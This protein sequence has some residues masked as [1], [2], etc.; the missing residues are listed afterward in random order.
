MLVFGHRGVAAE[1]Q[2]T[3]AGGV[4]QA[5]GAHGGAPVVAAERHERGIGQAQALAGGHEAAG[6]RAQGHAGA[7]QRDV[8][9]VGHHQLGR[10]HAGAVVFRVG[11][12]CGRTGQ[13]GAVG[14][15]AEVQRARGRVAQQAF[16]IG[17][18]PGQCA[19]DRE[20][21]RVVA[22]GREDH[23]A[24]RRLPLGR[25]GRAAQRERARSGIPLA[26]DAGLLGEGQRVAVGIAR[27]NAH[28]GLGERGAVVA[29]ALAGVNGAGC[30]RLLGVG[31]CAAAGGQHRGVVAGGHPHAHGGGGH[32]IGGGTAPAGV[33]GEVGRAASAAAGLVPDAHAQRGGA[34][35]L[36]VGHKAHIVKFAQQARRAVADRAQAA[37]RAAAVGRILP[38]AAASH[39]LADDG[40]PQ[41]GN[42]VHVADR[43]FLRN[44]RADALAGVV[45]RR[46]V[47]ADVQQGHRAR[48]DGERRVVDSG[49]GDAGAVDLGGEGRGGAR[50]DGL[51]GGMRRARALVPGAVA[52]GGGATVV[53]VGHEADAIGRAQQQRRRVAHG[54][55]VQPVAGV[56]HAVLPAAVV[57]TGGGQGHALN[58]AVVQVADGVAHQIG[59]GA[60][61]GRRCVF[62][63]AT[64]HRA[65][66]GHHRRV[67]AR[68]RREGERFEERHRDAG[69][70]H[71][72]AIDFV[73]GESHSEV[74]P[75]DVVPQAC[76]AWN[77]LRVV[78]T[79]VVVRL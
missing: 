14:H 24:Q 22:G 73:G 52:E 15:G 32:R 39:G 6:R 27:R 19:A 12:A 51:S 68:L 55:D 2:H 38:V 63:D 17:G 78:L 43:G 35:R 59:H 47:F 67:V 70:F 8:V 7:G 26:G 46:H 42:G 28:L 56:V 37:P 21:G 71:Q 29:H 79:E 31:G 44:Q 48:A 4:A 1:R 11:E 41:R 49:H 30:S 34:A 25:R 58:R 5:D 13:R 72:V 50:G 36:A 40:Q 18:L 9:A 65:G 53:A 20:L 62:V 64:E 75:I 61:L 77:H 60:G 45:V 54:A 23:A 66:R 10:Q 69:V 57:A 74:W 33:A 3:G 76:A 16:G